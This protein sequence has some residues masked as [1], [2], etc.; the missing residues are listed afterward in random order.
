[1]SLR[2][3]KEWHG[4]CF[5]QGCKNGA[6]SLAEGVQAGFSEKG[7]ALVRWRAPAVTGED[8]MEGTRKGRM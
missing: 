8:L 3:K 6:L 2:Y 5:P 4:P 1:M 7:Q